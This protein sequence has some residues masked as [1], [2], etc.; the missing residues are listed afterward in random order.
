MSKISPCL[1]FDG[2]A[3]EAANFYVS[4]FPDSYVD[5]VSRAPGDYPSGSAQ[6]IENETA[7]VNLKCAP[8]LRPM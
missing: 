3:E 7:S 5:K 1:W 2:H 4:L 6:S 8:P